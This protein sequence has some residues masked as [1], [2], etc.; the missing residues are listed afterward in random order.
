[1]FGQTGLLFA[2]RQWVYV[3]TRNGSY[4]TVSFP[5]AFPNGVFICVANFCGYSKDNT[6]A[7][8]IWND[9]ETTRSTVQFLLNG[10]TNSSPKCI[11]I[12][13]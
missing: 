9:G 6:N 10:A 4:R 7:C 3:D 1:M 11:A 2:N 13:H 5:I 12:G 8:I